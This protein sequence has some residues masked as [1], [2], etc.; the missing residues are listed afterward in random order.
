M[1]NHSRET[2]FNQLVQVYK[3]R[4]ENGCIFVHGSFHEVSRFIE[5]SCAKAIP[6]S[7]A[8]WV[9]FQSAPNGRFMIGLPTLTNCHCYCSSWFMIYIDL[10]MGLFGGNVNHFM[11]GEK[12]IRIGDISGKHDGQPWEPYG[13]DPNG[14][15]THPEKVQITIKI[16]I[17]RL[18]KKVLACK[19]IS[20]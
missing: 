5:K 15:Q 14:S 10:F 9:G 17:E 6:K 11:M 12:W 7:F 8:F 13:Y 4:W 3:S 20:H 1:T 18:P 19:G 16:I 2:I